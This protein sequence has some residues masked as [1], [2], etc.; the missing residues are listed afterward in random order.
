MRAE[1]DRLVGVGRHIAA[2]RATAAA[3]R[4]VAEPRLLIVF[5]PG[6]A[7]LAAAGE[8]LAA[9]APGVPVI[10]CAATGH[11]EVVV[12]ALGGDGFTVSTSA[13]GA[14]GGLRDAGAEAAA[15]LG[16]VAD[17]P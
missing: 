3:L 5:A 14:A 13:A 11:R 4:G 2:Q 8:T 1:I 16:D 17:R 12:A 6:G 7:E 9:V 10:G 15:C